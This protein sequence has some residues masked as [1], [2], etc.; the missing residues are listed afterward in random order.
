MASSHL[1]VRMGKVLRSTDMMPLTLLVSVAA[2]LGSWGAGV[3]WSRVSIPR[4]PAATFGT[5]VTRVMWLLPLHKVE[6][7]TFIGPIATLASQA[8]QL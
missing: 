6:L 4:I 7:G 1:S 5:K 3:G 8:G 2:A